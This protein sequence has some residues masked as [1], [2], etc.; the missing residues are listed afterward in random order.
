MGWHDQFHI[1]QIT[2]PGMFYIGRRFSCQLITTSLSCVPSLITHII[3]SSFERHS[4]PVGVKSYL[5]SIYSAIILKCTCAFAVSSMQIIGHLSSRTE[6]F[7]PT[8]KH[9]VK[10]HVEEYVALHNAINGTNLRRIF[11]AI[12]TSEET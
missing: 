6:A 3:V 2:F 4:L 5:R 7:Y 12:A 1:F 10:Q 8:L 11:L 9:R